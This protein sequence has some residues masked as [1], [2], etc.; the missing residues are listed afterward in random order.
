[1]LQQYDAYGDVSAC[2]MTCAHGDKEMP[3]EPCASCYSFDKWVRDI[4]KSLEE[5]DG[6]AP[7]VRR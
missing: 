6:K 2:C 7:E 4:S 1:M 5:P 3:E